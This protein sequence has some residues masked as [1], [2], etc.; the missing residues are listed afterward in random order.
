MIPQANKANNFLINAEAGVESA[1]T[2]KL[3]LQLVLQ[4][5]Y[6]N[7]PAPGRKN[8]DLRLISALAFKFLGYNTESP[9]EVV[10]P[11]C[12]RNLQTITN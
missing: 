1:L 9:A 6:A 8:N 3:N 4:D 10:I 12:A 5:N 2:E 11:Q 7:I